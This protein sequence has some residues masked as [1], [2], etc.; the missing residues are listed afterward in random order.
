MGACVLTRTIF[1]GPK[2]P[3]LYDFSA[4]PVES[5]SNANR[6]V[7]Y[8]GWLQVTS[9]TQSGTNYS[10]V[11]TKINGVIAVTNVSYGYAETFISYHWV[12]KGWNITQE[13]TRGSVAYKLFDKLK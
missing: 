1:Q 3:D 4:T 11:T 10:N 12:Q 8:N 9:D 2:S 6:T 7:S 13:L 5:W